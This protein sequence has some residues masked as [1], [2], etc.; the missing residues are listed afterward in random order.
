MI[1]LASP[2]IDLYQAAPEAARL[3]LGAS[4]VFRGEAGNPLLAPRG[5]FLHDRTLLV[6]DTGQN[7]VFIWRDFEPGQLHA[8]AACVLGQAQVGDTGRNAGAQASAQTLHY[9]SGLWTDGEKLAVADAWNHRVLLWHCFP[10]HTGQPADVVVGQP[11]FAHAAPNV[12]GI[13]AAPTARSLHWPYGVWSDGQRLWIADTGNRRVLVFDRWPD[14]N[15]A[16]ADGLIGKAAFDE[17]DY[18][19]EGPVWPYAVKVGPAGELAIADTQY[20][21]VLCWPHW[22]QALH[23]AA[24]TV[25][26]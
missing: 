8:A 6:A 16:A 12:A 19:P 25:I 1:S 7:R 17:R 23:Q 2:Q 21:R 11:D 13:G 24:P 3:V 15:G 5:V 9:P 14:R 10:T 26:G 22:Q 20:Y 18:D 4:W